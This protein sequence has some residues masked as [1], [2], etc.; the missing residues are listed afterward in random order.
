MGKW[1]IEGWE[2]RFIWRRDLFEW[3]KELIQVLL[4]ELSLIQMN[5]D[6]KDRWVWL[7]EPHGCYTVRS[8]YGTQLSRRETADGQFYKAIW[9]SPVPSK[10]AGLAWKV[11]LQ[12]LPTIDNLAKRGV[13]VN[14]NGQGSCA[15]CRRHDEDNSHVIFTCSFSYGIWMACYNWLKVQTALPMD[16]ITHFEHHGMWGVGGNRKTK[17]RVI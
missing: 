2:W 11:A 14:L 15:F 10:V 6:A 17:W 3:E 7:Q 1:G 5:K 16:C 9:S 8:A 12:R 13:T 4:Q